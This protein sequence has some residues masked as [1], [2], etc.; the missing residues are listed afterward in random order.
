M[1]AFEGMQDSQL[2]ELQLPLYPILEYPAD[3]ATFCGNVHAGL[4]PGG[5]FYVN[6][7]DDVHVQ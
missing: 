3:M 1:A 4:T 7:K 5:I 2:V 6:F